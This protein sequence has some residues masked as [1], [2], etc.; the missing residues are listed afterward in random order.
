M[1]YAVAK[2]LHIIGFISWFA[3][4]FYLPRLFIYHA[5]A[6]QKS[7]AE[8]EV[9][10]AQLELMAGRLWKIITV[11]A[12][13]V[14]LAAGT[15]MLVLR[16]GP[17]PTWLHIKFGFLALL[18]V[19]HHMCGRIRRQQS[20]GESTWTSRNLRIFNEAATMLMVAIVFLAVLKSGLNALWGS[21]GF[22]AFGISLMLGIRLYA[23]LRRD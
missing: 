22:V 5:E 6:V 15:T 2:A 19:Y 7:E 12:M 4:L 20:A 8:R 9:L 1:A 14:T 17:L 16:V 10:Q 13:L 11:P 18:L 21:L 23:K 3:G